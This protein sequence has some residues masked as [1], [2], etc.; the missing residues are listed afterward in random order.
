M[1]KYKSQFSTLVS[2]TLPYSLRLNLARNINTASMVTLQVKFLSTVYFLLNVPHIFTATI[3]QIYFNALHYRS[4]GRVVSKM[5]TDIL[6]ECTASIFRFEELAVQAVI[7]I[8]TI[9]THDTTLTNTSS[10][11]RA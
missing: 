5:L 10:T 7:K 3:S 9:T 2:T 4:W 6:E 8:H 1:Y 11:T